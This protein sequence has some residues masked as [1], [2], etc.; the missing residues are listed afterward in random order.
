[1]LSFFTW[2]EGFKFESNDHLS[3]MALKFGMQIE[4][5]TTEK[6]VLINC[7]NIMEGREGTQFMSKISLGKHV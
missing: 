3:H 2:V 1:M 5:S 6:F 7:R 4:S